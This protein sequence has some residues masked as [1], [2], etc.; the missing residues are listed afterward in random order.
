LLGETAETLPDTALLTD[1]KTSCAIEA[2]LL[3]RKS[4]ADPERMD[5]VIEKLAQA[6]IVYVHRVMIK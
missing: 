6:G 4:S 3:A 5:E 2:S 1:T